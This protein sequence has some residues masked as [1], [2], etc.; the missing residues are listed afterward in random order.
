MDLKEYREQCGFTQRDLAMHAGVGLKT[1]QEIERK[2]RSVG[3][4]R[5]ITAV[6]LA[7]VLGITVEQLTGKVFE[8]EEKLVFENDFVWFGKDKA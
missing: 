7:R 6:K 8:G 5:V 4:L 2:K 1:I 3:S